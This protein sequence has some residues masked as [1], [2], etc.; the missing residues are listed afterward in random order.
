MTGDEAPKASDENIQLKRNEEKFRLVVESAPSAMVMVDK[1][2]RITLV[3]R[4]AEKLFGFNRIELI[5]QSIEMLVPSRFHGKHPHDRSTYFHSPQTR[6]MGSG[7]DLFGLRKDGSEVPVEIGLNP[8]E[9]EDGTFVLAAIVD[10]TERKRAEERFRLVVEAA[11]NAMVMVGREGKIVLVNSQTEKLFGYV[12]EELIGQSIEILVPPDSRGAHPGHRMGFNADPKVRSMGVGRDLFGLRKNGTQVPV[13]I[14]LN[15]IQTDEGHFV[16]ASIIDITQR[17]RMEEARQKNEELEEQNRRIR[18]AN[19]LKS[20]FL[21]NMSHELRTPLNSVIG[22]SEIIQDGK[23][24]PTTDAQKEYLGDILTSA[25]HL[26]QLINDVL[27]LSKVE[28]GKM[29]FHPEDVNLPSL[30]RELRDTIQV[31]A[32]KKGIRIDVQIHPDVEQVRTDPS[33]LKQVLYNYLSNAI[34]F[35]SDRGLV[36]LELAPEGKEFFKLSVQDNGIGIRREDLHRLFVEFQQL[37]AS[38][39]KKYQGTG[40]GLALTRRIVEAQGGTV[41]V[42]SEFGKGSKFFAVLPRR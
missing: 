37:D 41:G 8:I 34:K 9:T 40:L 12:R 10:I 5:G 32:E 13:E 27:D 23:A 3:N 30:A 2:G 20:E 18:D 29:E 31:L 25:R 33:R 35:T 28:S 17:K 36:R 16:L 38:V 1:G 15:P 22:F 11:P 39:S 42:D 14:G 19:R 24:G 21:A 7:R 4:Q 26:L 6:P